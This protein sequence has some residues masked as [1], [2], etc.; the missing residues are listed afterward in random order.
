MSCSW[1][2]SRRA[3]A[4]RSRMPRS[5]ES[6]NQSGAS[7]SSLLG[8]HHLRPVLLG[9]L[10]LAQLVAGDPRPAGDE[11]LGELDLG[12]LEREEG[13]R[14]FVLHRDVFGDVGDQRALAHRRPRGDDDQVAGLEAAGDRVDVAEAGG[15][16]GQLELAGRELLE[17]VDLLVEDLG[18]HPEV[19]RLLF[20]GDFEEQFLGPLG[21]L[22]RLAVALVDPAAGFPGR[23]RA[24]AAAASSAGRFRRSAWR[25]RRRAPW[26]PARRRRAC[27]RPRRSGCA[28]SAPR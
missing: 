10:A 2:C 14:L 21:E 12:H 4:R 26:P 23:R 11:A 24:A 16:A 17:P 7:S 19:A 3:L 6:S 22:A 13:D 15:R 28:G 27:R 20:V 9:D 18:E 25:C 8:A 1:A 5:E